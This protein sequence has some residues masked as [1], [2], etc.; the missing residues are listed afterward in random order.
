MRVFISY[1][2]QDSEA[3]GRLHT[4]LSMLRRDGSI[5]EWFDREILAGSDID[6][7]ISDQLEH[8]ALF[9]LLV[10]PDFLASPYCYEREMARALA[11]HEA[12][13]ARVVPII[14]E[15][16]D[17]RS[18][19]LKHLKALPR[20]GLPIS[21]WTN[22][23]NAYVDIVQELRRVVTSDEGGEEAFPHASASPTR[24][25]R[26]RRYRV[27][28][29]FDEIDRSDFRVASFETI[30]SY[31]ERSI[32]EIG[33]IDGIRARYIPYSPSSFGCMLVN[34]SLEH[35]IA[36]L[37]VH[38]G[39]GGSMLGDIYYK[40]EE[41]ASANS[42]NGS[43]RIESDDYDLFLTSEG[44]MFFEDEKRLTSEQAAES[45]WTEFLEQ[46]GITHD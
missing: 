45:L 27:K 8:C 11:R 42:A 15:P 22:A 34:T 10:S 1:S 12:G 44:G 38:M 18:T 26:E 30:R 4:H 19:P 43:Y 32:A 9:L 28:R 25:Q 21:E 20:D 35:G 41:N 13:E 16:C 37:T 24:P 7:D 5:D 46:A 6:Q 39:G 40:F 14:V 2:H 23:N 17:W 3:L 29:E 31:F 33:T 36:H